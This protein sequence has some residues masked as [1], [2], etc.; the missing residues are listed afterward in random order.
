MAS[1]VGGIITP[2]LIADD[3]GLINSTMWVGSGLC[4]ISLV[5]GILLVMV[6]KYADT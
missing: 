4:V 2:Y 6:D 3:D 1:V 5:A